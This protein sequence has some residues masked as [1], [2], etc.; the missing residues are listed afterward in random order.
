MEKQLIHVLF[1]SVFSSSWAQRWDQ[2]SGRSLSTALQASNQRKDFMEVGEA[3]GGLEG[4]VGDSVTNAAGEMPHELLWLLLFASAAESAAPRT[5]DGCFW[6]GG[7]SCW[8]WEEKRAGIQH[9]S[10][11]LHL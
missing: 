1:L 9:P 2:K 3:G 5:L 8:C 10:L 6:E 7:S 4:D 11:H